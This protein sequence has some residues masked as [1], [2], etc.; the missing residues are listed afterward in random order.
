MRCSLARRGGAALAVVLLSGGFVVGGAGLWSS[1][2]SADECPAPADPI[3]ATPSEARELLEGTWLACSDASAVPPLVDHGE[4]GLQFTNEG[5]WYRVYRDDEGVL[6]RPGGLDH[7]GTWT[8]D[9]STGQLNIYERGQFIVHPTFF[10]SPSMVRFEDSMT[11]ETFDYRRSDEP[12]PVPGIPAGVGTGPCGLPTGFVTPA[13]P[14]AAQELLTGTWILCSGDPGFAT[15]DDHEVGLQF[16]ADGHW[17]RVYRA[18]DGTLIRAEGLDQDGTYVVAYVSDINT[19]VDLQMHDGGTYILGAVFLESPRF[20]RLGR[21]RPSPGDYLLWTGPEPVAGEPPG[22]EGWPCGAPGVPVVLSSLEQTE[23][24]LVGVWLRCQGASSI[25]GPTAGAPEIGLQ[26]TADGS[27]YYV[28]DGPGDTLFRTRQGTWR[29][30]EDSD[31][32]GNFYVTVGG[33]G[34][35]PTFSPDPPLLRANSMIGTSDHLRWTGPDPIDGVPPVDELPVDDVLPP[36]GAPILPITLLAG[37]A[38]VVGLTVTRRANR[39]PSL[40]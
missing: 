15:V 11:F 5:R 20:M 34:F 24:L 35:R 10:A 32:G 26:F 3:D 7:E 37:V 18:D 25:L 16:T 21:E 30:T 9:D 40:R 36:T 13:S 8:I 38:I 23:D 4:V 14:D 27:W 1:P 33:F 17:Y 22:S 2:A 31:V 28:F 29:I 39:R 19:Q 12:A 6:I